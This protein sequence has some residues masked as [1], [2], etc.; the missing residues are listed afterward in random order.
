M[1]SES[2]DSY[3]PPETVDLPLVTSQTTGVS[4]TGQ[5][6]TESS[7]S[8]VVSSPQA[9]DNSATPLSANSMKTPTK[10]HDAGKVLDT[11][12]KKAKTGGTK[13]KPKFKFDDLDAD[14][15]E[16]AII[17]GEQR[18]KE[19]LQPVGGD[20][21]EITIDGK[22]YHVGYLVKLLHPELRFGNKGLKNL[23]GFTKG[24]PPS[25]PVKPTSN[26]ELTKL[27]CG[28]AK[29]DTKNKM[30][31]QKGSRAFKVL[32]GHPV[33]LVIHD[34][35]ETIPIDW[36]MENPTAP[37]T[38]LTFQITDSFGSRIKEENVLFLD[39]FIT[40]KERHD[41][42]QAAGSTHRAWK[43]QAHMDYKSQCQ[44][45]LKE[46]VEWEWELVKYIWTNH[47]SAVDWPTKIAD[48]SVHKPSSRN[49]TLE[50]PRALVEKMGLVTKTEKDSEDDGHKDEDGT[51]MV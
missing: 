8:V 21:Q 22:S 17:L 37:V 36:T 3:E 13:A 25:I 7:D 49:D 24:P 34:R 39:G 14:S 6:S 48:I 30:W 16:Y 47:R 19:S 12:T 15:Q 31:S 43:V 23:A 33:Y 29:D 45:F 44:K 38:D 5:L 4:I 35:R 46:R 1:A 28:M 18:Y 27:H 11:P 26:P 20:Y 41:K 10:K 50:D 42:A 40:R 9:I 51:T 32:A 2:D